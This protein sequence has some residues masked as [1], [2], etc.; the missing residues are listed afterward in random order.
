MVE[1]IMDRRCDELKHDI[2]DSEGEAMKRLRSD[3]E[4]KAV[5]IN[6]TSSTLLEDK[7]TQS[8]EKL[9]NQL[10][11]SNAEVVKCISDLSTIM[12]R[13]SSKVDV[14]EEIVKEELCKKRKRTS[15]ESERDAVSDVV[16]TVGGTF[17]E[18]SHQH[19]EDL[20]KKEPLSVLNTIKRLCRRG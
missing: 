12:G 1:T 8:F 18:R 3:L 17:D 20:V 13:L 5:S 7:M 2:V 10:T 4:T 15:M 14:N 6:L 16:T 11:T 19:E 9:T